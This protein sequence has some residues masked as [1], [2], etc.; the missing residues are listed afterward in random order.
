ME[1][2]SCCPEWRSL[3]CGS[4]AHAEP[5]ATSNS[6]VPSQ[7]PRGARTGTQRPQ[8]DKGIGVLNT[9]DSYRNRLP[10]RSRCLWAFSPQEQR[11]VCSSPLVSAPPS[12]L[13]LMQECYLEHFCHAILRGGSWVIC[14]P[15]EL[16]MC[17]GIRG[18]PGQL[19][20]QVEP[21]Y[22]ETRNLMYCAVHR[23]RL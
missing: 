19:V 2:I 23:G 5:D 21:M 8:G 15:G 12:P 7:F 16:G 10:Q 20:R 9:P 18:D 22:L 1:V 11:G 6:V 17:L 14:S 13:S 4:L 3:A